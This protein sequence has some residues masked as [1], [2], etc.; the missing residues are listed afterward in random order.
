LLQIVS[1][2]VSTAASF[3]IFD[4][5]ERAATAI[6][7]ERIL[8]L[9]REN[10]ARAGLTDRKADAALS[11]ADA[12]AA[13]RIRLDALPADDAS[14]LRQLT[15]KMVRGDDLTFRGPATSSARER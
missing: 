9:G 4:R 12:V 13:D 1:Q 6:T 11:L 2:H 5:L 14:A 15:A 3:T 10:L 8:A 7:P